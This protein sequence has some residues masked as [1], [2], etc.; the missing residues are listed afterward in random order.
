MTFSDIVPGKLRAFWSSW[1]SRCGVGLCAV[2][3]VVTSIY[4]Y[5]VSN[6]FILYHNP[7]TVEELKAFELRGILFFGLPIFIGLIVILLGTVHALNRRN[8]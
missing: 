6:G 3:I 7:L 1:Y 2:A 8:R 5:L 4:D